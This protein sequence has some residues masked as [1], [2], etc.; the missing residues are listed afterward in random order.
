MPPAGVDEVV[1][2]ELSH[3]LDLLLFRKFVVLAPLD[4]LVLEGLHEL[5]D[6]GLASMVCNL[7]FF[8]TDAQLK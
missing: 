2:D 3:D 1:I 8:V 7:F 5:V 4:V 6:A